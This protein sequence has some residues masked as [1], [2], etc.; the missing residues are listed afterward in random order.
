MINKIRLKRTSSREWQVYPGIVRKNLENTMYSSGA[1]HQGFLA[2]SRGF[3]GSFNDRVVGQRAKTREQDEKPEFIGPDDEVTVEEYQ[4]HKE[5]CSLFPILS[6]SQFRWMYTA[7]FD[8]SHRL[9][10]IRH[11]IRTNYLAR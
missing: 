3:G 10:K 11:V 4:Q 5:E 8:E 7:R 9:A 6:P 1:V 2:N